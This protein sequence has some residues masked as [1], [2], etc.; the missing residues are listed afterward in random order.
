MAP[1]APLGPA[2]PC[3]MRNKKELVIAGE[4]QGKIMSPQD[5]GVMTGG[6][7]MRKHGDIQE[8]LE[9]WGGNGH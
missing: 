1:L 7:D 4:G 9:G 8:A 2:G 3:E 6:A 5:P